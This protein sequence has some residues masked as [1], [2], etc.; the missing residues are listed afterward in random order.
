M[1]ETF[2]KYSGTGLLVCWFLVAWFYLFFCE[3]KKENRV[4]LV[5]MPAVLLLLFFNPLFYKVFGNLTEEAIYF[6]FL[7]LLPITMVISYTV[8][9]IYSTLKGAM[10]YVF[11]LLSFV[12][13]VFSGRLVYLN[14]LFEKAENPYHVPQKV[15]EI[16]DMI[17]VEGRE[18]V[19]AFP[20]EFILYVRQYSATVCMPY[21]RDVF[22]YYDPFYSMMNEAVIEVE[23]LAE[24]AKQA[25][26]HYIVLSEEKELDGN[27]EE[28]S[29]EVFGRVDK[30]VI[31]R[32][33]DIYIGL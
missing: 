28:Y 31:Y 24:L 23:E 25:G 13:I 14:P 4:L 18:V 19:A 29:Y 10:Q 2:Q 17:E 30:Y 33:V 20:R 1:I 11:V 6:R 26:C 7:W 22:S 12:L 16:C 9:K 32:D 21:G 8:I 27:L 3:K 15:V 5:Y